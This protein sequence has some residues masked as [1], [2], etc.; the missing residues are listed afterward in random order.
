[1]MTAADMELKI[2]R[3]N[4]LATR[5]YSVISRSLRFDSASV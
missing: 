1:M 2:D 5:L 3:M 4:S